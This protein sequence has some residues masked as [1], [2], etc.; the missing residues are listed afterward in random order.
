MTS[1]LK[2]RVK[3]IEEKNDKS[4]NYE[5]F[6]VGDSTL[7]VGAFKEIMKLINGKTRSL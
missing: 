6:T 5:T 2:K 7:T 4:R 1:Q 3:K